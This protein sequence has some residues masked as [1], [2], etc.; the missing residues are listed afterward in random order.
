MTEP[1]IADKK[2]VKVDLEKGKEYFFCTCGESGNQPFCDG[3]HSGTAF[4]PM[5]FIAEKDGPAFLC[6]CKRSG[7]LPFCDGKHKEL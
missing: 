1:K 2:S 3:S 4:T 7:K 5:A 6:A